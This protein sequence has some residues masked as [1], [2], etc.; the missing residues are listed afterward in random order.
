VSYA[1]DGDG[2]RVSRSLSGTLT[3]YLLDTQPG[4]TVVL[5]EATG[6]NMTR[7][8]HGPT[9]ILAQQN[10]DN[11]MH[12]MLQDGLQSVRAISDGMNVLSA[13]AYSPYG[14]PMFTDMPT[15]FGF[16]GEQTDPTN[17]LVYLRARYM[18]PKLGVFGSLD[19]FEGESSAP[20]TMNGYGWVE[21]NTPN[22]TDATGKCTMRN[23]REVASSQEAAEC[24]RQVHALSA[25]YGIYLTTVD[26]QS[27]EDLW[28]TTRVGNIYSTVQST[29]AAINR[30][31][32]G[33][34]FRQVFGNTT[35]RAGIGEMEGCASTVSGVASNQID[36]G[37]C[38]ADDP[39]SVYNIIHE[40]GHVLKFRN[41]V[42][43]SVNEPGSLITSSGEYERLSE[44]WDRMLVLTQGHDEYNPTD[45]S[46][47][48]L[49]SDVHRGFQTTSRGH[50]RQNT[51]QGGRSSDEEVAD[52]FLFWLRPELFFTNDRQGQIRQQFVQGFSI[53]NFNSSGL[54]LISL[55]MAKWIRRAAQNHTCAEQER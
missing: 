50:A 34:N 27:F 12:W 44:T 4:L 37:P 22:L 18:N 17:D 49:F 3:R 6:A 15:E 30:M 16:T 33:V 5:S 46:R 9:G 47:I 7:Y 35:F 14:E 13:Q 53:A 41:D 51:G 23:L 10:P 43:A 11:A 29:E 8:I 1:Y 24:K 21:G 42:N 52:M 25:Y 38:K 20:L 48:Y 39:Y 40:L 45:E 32:V 55:G 26:S 31:E 36:L 2:D 54:P 28:T 19:P